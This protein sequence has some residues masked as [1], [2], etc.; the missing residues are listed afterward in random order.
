[1]KV[2]KGIALGILCFLLFILLTVFGFAYTAH[3]IA[4][5]PAFI[6]SVIDDID[7]AQVA[8]E[9][10]TQQ[11]SN[12]GG[13]SPE[14]VNAVV[15]SLDKAQPVIKQNIN[16]AVRDTYDYLLGKANAPDLKK[17][18][19]DTFLNSQFVDSVLQKIDLAQIVDQAMQE[20]TSSG[21]DTASKTL[22]NS[23]VDTVKT[24]EPDIKKQVVA[25]SDPI[26]SYLLGKTQTIDLK[27]TLRK[28]I[29]SRDLMTAT[30][31]ALNIKSITSDM[32]NDELDTQLPQGVA[33]SNADVSQI[34]TALEPAVKQSLVNSADAVAD[35]IIGIKPQFTAIV[36][37]EPALPTVKAVVKQA[38]KRQLP[39]ELATATPAQIDQ[40]YEVYW[41]MER[42]NIPSLFVVD[43]STLGT[44]VPD[45]FN[46]MVTS[47]QSGL[48]DARDSI[49]QATAD[50]AENLD[51]IRPAVGIAQLVYWGLILLILALIGAVVLIQRSVRGATRDLGITF[52][53]YGAI[54]FAGTFVVRTI[55]GK[56]EFIQS[57]AGGDMPQTALDI[58]APLV[59]KLTQPLFIFTLICLVI[60]IALLVVSFMYARR[61]RTVEV[62]QPADKP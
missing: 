37:V 28:T 57:V 8:R 12:G 29:L 6:N 36:S 38:F 34:A 23:I 50:L 20:Q 26:F 3:Q 32:L 16:I 47:M 17:T 54:F 41:G 40:A 60:G 22:T 2:L 31:N 61:R 52:T 1:M 46:E 5:S 56:P 27:S 43:S 11:Q 42:A 59:M 58:I 53:C 30:I 39:P 4:L 19:G 13:P 33:L 10:M 48:R 49:D 7:F 45:A 44:E 15:D 55:I 14:L 51:Q 62:T 18:L 21:S 35:Y 9:V 25:A 24:L